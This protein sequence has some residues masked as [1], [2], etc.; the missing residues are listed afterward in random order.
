M[1]VQL[2]VSLL[3]AGCIAGFAAAQEKLTRQIY[4]TSRD[5]AGGRGGKG[6]YVYD[7]GADR[8]GMTP[9]GKKLYVPSGWWNSDKHVKVVDAETG[10]TLKKIE[11]APEGGLHNLI[12]SHD[13]RRVV[14]GST[15]YDMLSV[16]DTKTDEVIQRVGPIIGVIQ[17]LSI[18]GAGTL[19]YV[20]T[21]LYR[22]GH[23]PGFEIGDL[24]TGKILHVVGRPELSDRRSRCH[25]IGLTPDEREVWVVDQGYKED[26]K[27][28]SQSRHIGRPRDMTQR[29]VP[30]AAVCIVV[31][32]LV[33]ATLSAGEGSDEKDFVPLFDGKSFEGWHIMNGG[34]FVVEDGVIK[35]NG[36]RGW[37]RSDKEYSDFVLRLQLRFMKPKQDGGVFLRASEEGSGWPTR[38]YEVQS[39]NSP[40]MAKLFGAKYE[41]DVELT[42]KALNPD[43]QWNEYEITLA[44]PRIEV[45][46]NGK[47][48]TKS[49]DL[50]KLTRGYIGL[51]GEGGFHE[52]RKIRIKG[53][54]Q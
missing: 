54:S 31:C 35:L 42:R 20:N 1:R 44:G 41:Q 50:G 34:Q 48:V 49:D 37:L 2:L 24:K 36:G 22:K 14:V 5:G 28:K 10:K 53:N 15:H 33:T 3:I 16:I 39:E 11:V 30:V 45:R 32:S 7:I 12:V 23:G 13:G 27:R 26:D 46:L 4:V 8:I 18:N 29:I 25:G 43:G 38:R 21:H 6:I 19:A 51:Q 9:D 52:Y 40:R 47:L 17:P